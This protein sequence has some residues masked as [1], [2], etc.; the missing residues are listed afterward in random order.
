[1]KPPRRRVRAEHP[2]TSPTTPRPGQ[3]VVLDRA[4]SVQ[5]A[6]DRGLTAAI[7]QVNDWSTTEGWMWLTVAVLD[8]PAARERAA[9]RTVFVRPAGLRS[10]GRTG[11]LGVP[12]RGGV[13]A[14]ESAD[15]VPEF[16]R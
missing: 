9:V 15:P 1:M 3:V 10:A 4:A 5:F 2:A 13:A 11:L 16:S 6:G 12:E 8:P 7:L 14:P